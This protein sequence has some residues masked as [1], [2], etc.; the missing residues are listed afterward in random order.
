[1]S[2]RKST[3]W[4]SVQ[5]RIR[6]QPALSPDGKW[7]AYQSTE[8][9]K[10]EIFVQ[11]FPDGGSRY[12]VPSDQNNHHPIWSAD[13]RDLF[14]IPRIGVSYALG[15]RTGPRFTFATPA[16]IDRGGRIEGPPVA[17]RNHDITPDGRIIG[18]IPG[19]ASAASLSSPSDI[20]VIL[21]WFDDLNAR[22]PA[23]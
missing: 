5:S 6:S 1:V 8:T 11:P 4:G 21:N 12:M 22:V 3:Q 2:D 13:G 16:A 17:N 7:I 14:Y 23:R 9:G 15:V 19:G 18:V 10:N 20:R